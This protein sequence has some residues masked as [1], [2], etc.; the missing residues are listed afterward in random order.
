VCFITL[1]CLTNLLSSQVALAQTPACRLKQATLR[2]KFASDHYVLQGQKQDND[3]VLELTIR[4]TRETF[5]FKVQ[6]DP[7]RRE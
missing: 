1:L 5:R 4:Q 3:M 7:A 6:V 2:P